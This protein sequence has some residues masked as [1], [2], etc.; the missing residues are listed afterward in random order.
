MP[1]KKQ[2]RNAFFFFMLDYKARCERNGERFPNGLRDV[3]TEASPEWNAMSAETRKPYEDMAKEEKLRIKGDDSCNFTNTHRPFS[4][5]DKEKQEEMHAIAKMKDYIESTVN[6]L[7]NRKLLA[8][9]K[10]Y[11]AHVNYFCTTETLEYIP[12]EVAV[13]EFC[14][15]EG[16]TNVFHTLIK[17]SRIPLGYQHDAMQK[18]DETHKIPPR[19]GPG[20]DNMNVIFDGIKKILEPGRIANGGDYPPLFTMSENIHLNTSIHAVKNLMKN[21]SVNCLGHYRE[22]YFP[23]YNLE[24]LFFK[25]HNACCELSDDNASEVFPTIG[26]ANIEL[27]RDIY[28]YTQSIACDFHAEQDAVS[29][30]S[31]SFVQRWVYL[32][33]DHCCQ[34]LDIKLQTGR[35]IP[36]NTDVECIRPHAQDN[37][38]NKAQPMRSFT[39]VDFSKQKTSFVPVE[40]APPPKPSTYGI[41]QPDPAL[42][43]SE[44]NFPSMSFGRGRGRLAA[45]NP[46][47]TPLSFADRLK[48]K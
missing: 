19:N 48:K 18:C 27:E 3:Q 6:G 26:I 1:K 21:C 37:Q 43:C 7:R 25:L 45:S 39:I 8:E 12:A 22:D 23:V 5:V 35:H 41:P 42:T 36:K 40:E 16:I 15:G 32:I 46:K 14:L 28:N 33:C 38:A 17:G 31:Q 2:P 44:E 30:C 29:N 13:A 4:L 9:H 20:T 34:Y 24:N 47:P 10:F 11:L